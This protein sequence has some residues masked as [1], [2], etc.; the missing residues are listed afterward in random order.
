MD[1]ALRG[2]IRATLAAF[3]SRDVKSMSWEEAM[4]ILRQNPALV[5]AGNNVSRISTLVNKPKVHFRGGRDYE[6]D[7]EVHD[8]LDGK[9][10]YLS[11]WP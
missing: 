3:A 9:K 2:A 6:V 7:R 10:Q 5:D 11:A 8:S 1:Q 4:S